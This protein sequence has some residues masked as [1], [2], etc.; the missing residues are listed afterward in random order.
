MTELKPDEK[1]CPYCAET[2]KAAAVKCRYCHSDLSEAA[3]GPAVAT[4]PRDPDPVEPAPAPASAPV[5]KAPPEPAPPAPEPA[6]PAP[7]PADPTRG[8][9][10]AALDSFR[11]LV[12]LVVLCLVLAAVAGFAWW[13]AENPSGDD[14]SAGPITS[15]E[16][17]DA[18][19]QEATRLTQ[20][21]LSYD[22]KTLD[23]D[24][25]ASENLLAPSFRG[26]YTRAM[27]GV[28]AQT[29][30]NQVKLTADAVATSIVSASDDKVEALVFVNQVTTAKGTGNQRL[31][32][33][34][35]L[36]TLTRHGGEWR[37]S[38]MDAF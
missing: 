29:V 37:V 2:I 20:Q 16:A 1:V 9:L 3:P 18:G 30:K 23:E 22:W 10:A 27:E 5:E 28:K 13:R 31:D 34:R 14:A 17:R 24:I 32:Q 38:K 33:N 15:A 7:A 12:V 19:L 26:E 11:L 25:T 8:R 4:D 6:A 36:V 35:V 21:V